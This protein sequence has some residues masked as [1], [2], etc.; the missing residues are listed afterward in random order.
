MNLYTKSVIVWLLIAFA[1][2]IHG[3]LRAKLLV[4]KVGDLRSRQIGVFSGSI[5]IFIITFYSLSFIGPKTTSDTFI[6]GGIWL[7]F[8]LLFEFLVGHFI[9]RF[10]WKWL[11]DEYNVKKGRLLIFG[12]I[13]LFTVPYIVFHFYLN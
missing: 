7:I 9:F 6:I 1:E 4:P 12:M 8:M 2:T 13:F 10:P 5:I 11:L 3:I